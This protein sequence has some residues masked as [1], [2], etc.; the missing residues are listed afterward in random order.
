MQ[1][2]EGSRDV[3]VNSPLER[4]LRRRETER[5]PGATVGSEKLKVRLSGRCKA[6]VGQGRRRS[7]QGR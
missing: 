4:P 7:T 1:K 5:G 2:G 6:D 3:P